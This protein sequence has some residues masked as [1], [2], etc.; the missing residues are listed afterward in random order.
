MSDLSSMLDA[1]DAARANIQPVD[2][3]AQL[4]RTVKFNNI[5][6]IARPLAEKC[7]ELY[8]LR[9]NLAGVINAGVNAAGEPTVLY[10]LKRAKTSTQPAASVTIYGKG[11]VTFAGCPAIDE[12]GNAIPE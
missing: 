12:L 8:G 5:S 3:P 11:S 9:P 1:V 7:M 10:A 6:E 4:V 2:R